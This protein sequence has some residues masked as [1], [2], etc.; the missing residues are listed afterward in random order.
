M[1]IV[2]FK[3]GSHI[4]KYDAYK[5]VCGRLTIA[6]LYLH[7]F[8]EA[9]GGYAVRPLGVANHSFF[10]VRKRFRVRGEEYQVRYGEYG[11]DH[12]N[13]NGYHQSR[14]SA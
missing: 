6:I 7:V 11:A 5:I 2:E 13:S 4:T 3:I 9:F 1:I 10:A 12:P 8:L 14:P